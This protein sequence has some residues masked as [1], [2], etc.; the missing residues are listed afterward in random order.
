MKTMKM[1]VCL[2][3]LTMAL[4]VA[5]TAEA[6]VMEN[7]LGRNGWRTNGMRF[8]G[9]SAQVCPEAGPTAAQSPVSV[10]CPG[11]ERQFDFGAV[12][13]QSIE[14]PPQAPAKSR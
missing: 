3:T 8:N 6:M 5:G 13:L 14:L 7:G 1:R 9:V 12:S 4:L 2:G 11:G 10:A